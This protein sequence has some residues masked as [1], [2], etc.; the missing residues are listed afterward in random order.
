[1]SVELVND[2]YDFILLTRFDTVFYA[3]FQFEKL[4]TN[5]F[6]ITNW[7]RSGWENDKIF[8]DGWFLSGNCNMMNFSKIYDRYREYMKSGSDYIKLMGEDNNKISGH[9]IWWYRIYR[10]KV[11][12]KYIYSWKSWKLMGISE[13]S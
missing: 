11:I 4:D 13:K 2:Q 12:N 8:G 10:I 9:T 5:A 6:Y 7:E 1:M 3:P